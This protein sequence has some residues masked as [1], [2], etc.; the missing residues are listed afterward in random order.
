M[1]G[2]VVDYLV[3]DAVGVLA[4]GPLAHIAEPQLAAGDTVSVGCAA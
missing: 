1:E 4:E 2:F 3:V